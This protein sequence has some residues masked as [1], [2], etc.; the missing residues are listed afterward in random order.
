M[1]VSAMQQV[2]SAL[3]VYIYTPPSRAE[4]L[5]YNEVQV[6][7]VSFMHCTLGIAFKISSPCLSSRFSS[8]FFWEFYSFFFKALQIF[9]SCIQISWYTK[10]NINIIMSLFFFFFSAG[11]NRMQDL[12]FPTRYWTC[13]L[14]SGSAEFKPLDHQGSRRSSVVSHF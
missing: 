8:V 14:C 11:L 9:L 7:V 1:L 5:N 13:T 10:F 12:S 4:V 3:S 6:S 2:K